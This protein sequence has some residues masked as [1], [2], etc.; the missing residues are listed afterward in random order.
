MKEQAANTRLNTKLEAS[1][2]EPMTS[3][4]K[5][6]SDGVKLIQVRL[7]LGFR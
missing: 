5:D 4:A 3:L 2:Y 6:F 7:W 1:G